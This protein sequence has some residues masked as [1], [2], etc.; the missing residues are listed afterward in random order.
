MTKVKILVLAVLLGAVPS[1]SAQVVDFEDLANNGAG[2]FTFQGDNVVS[3]G[4]RFASVLQQGNPGAIASWTED[5]PDFYTGSVAIFANTGGDSLDMSL[6]GGGA[7]DVLSIDACDIFRAA[8]TAMTVTLTGT[9]ADSSIVSDSFVLV[10]SNDLTTYA[11]SGLTDVVSLNLSDDNGG[12]LWFQF[13][14]V[15]VNVVPEPATIVA[16]GIGAVALLRRRQ[17]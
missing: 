15:V 17:K 14:N 2:G 11:V 5:S 8:G 10:P 7:F 16:L 1:A 12:S 13:D 6:V 9:R 4:F 3:G